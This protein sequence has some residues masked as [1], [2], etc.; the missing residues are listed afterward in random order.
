M[1]APSSS[2]TGSGPFST[3]VLIVGAGPTGLMLA[4]WLARLGVRPLIVDGKAGPTRESRA[5]VVQARSLEA[6]DQLGVGAEVMARGRRVET[7]TFWNE[8]ERVARLG[9]GAAGVGL[10]PHPYLFA[11]EQSQNENILYA[12]LRDLGGD[13]QWQTAFEHLT[14]DAEGVTAFIRLPDGTRREVRARYVCGADGTHSPV[15]H[16]LAIPFEGSANDHLFYVADVIAQGA[17]DEGQFNFKIAAENFL[18]AFPIPGPNHFRLIG[19]VSFAHIAEDQ[20]RFEDVQEQIAAFGVQVSA[21]NWFSSY[22]V[23]HRVA[24]HFRRG[25]V[26]LA[27]DAAHVHSPVGAQGMNTGLLDAHNLAWKLAALLHDEAGDRLL[28]SYEA[29]RRPFALALV[30]TTDRA[31][32]IATNSSGIAAGLRGRLLPGLIKRLARFQKVNGAQ[33][34]PSEAKP[35]FLATFLF[36]L[37]SQIRIKYPQSPLSRGRAGHVRGGDR[38]P[39]VPLA[40]GGNFDALRDARAQLHVY[41]TPPPDAQTWATEHAAIE[42]KVFPFSRAADEA[43]LQADAVYL[44]RPDGYVSLAMPRFAAEELT[45]VL[46]DGWDWHAI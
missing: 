33:T 39:F 5:L 14:Q 1:T 22:R 13:V 40:E 9:F 23:S 3:D 35:T 21:V 43:G 28:D 15:R 10:T 42:L 31:F 44:V 34:T 18:L 20:A 38:L 4:N 45:D 27:G 17:V 41:G 7:I 36:G 24:A 12:H 25:H 32:G 11:L 37:V 26:F 30:R 16:A 6:Y 8:H 29:E 19:I 46:R 2:Q